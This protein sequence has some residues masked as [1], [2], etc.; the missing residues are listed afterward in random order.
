MVLIFCSAA[1]AQLVADP[2]DT[3]YTWISI[4]EERGYI[5]NLPLLRPY[6]IQLVKDILRKVKE[7]GSQADAALADL[8]LQRINVTIGDHIPDRSLLAPLSLSIENTFWTKFDSFR[9]DALANVVLQSTLGDLVSFSG[10]MSW[11]GMVQSDGFYGP[12]WL[13]ISDESE[14]GGG[15]ASIAGMQVWAKNLG[16]GG[17]AFGSADAYFQAG[18]MRSSFGPFFENGAI[19]GPQCPAAGNFSF[20]YTADWIKISSVMLIVH[21]LFYR[22]P[23]DLPGDFTLLP[24]G[25][26]SYENYLIIHSYTLTPLDWLE[27]G[28]VQTVECGGSLNPV[29]II[30][31]VNLFFAQQ[32]YGND[33]T[34]LIGLFAKIKLPFSFQFK[35]MLYVDDFNT[36]TFFG[37]NGAGLFSLDNA[38]DK[39]ALQA[40]I[41]WTP[42][43]DILERI[44]LDYLMVTPYTYTHNAGYG[45]RLSYT[46]QGVGI[47][48]IL[49]PNSDQI[50]LNAFLHPL[51]WCDIVVTG[52]FARHGNASEDEGYGGDGSYYDD[53]YNGSATFIAPARFLT[54]NVI[55]YVLQ[56]GCDINFTFGLGWSELQIGIGYM[57]EYVRNKNLLPGNEQ[58]NHFV[59]IFTKLIL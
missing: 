8:Y 50:T 16:V 41:V 2:K 22:D 56:L 28:L 27:F 4:W 11:G 51:S 44:S 36:D 6:P 12:E 7:H 49:E 24:L 15:N 30:P 58:Y 55:E 5:K 43:I 3:L 47:G 46:H 20:N 53:G 10:S 52:R 32:L 25:S 59:N 21:P 19:I 14:S 1:W 42:E 38:Q 37:K 34:S 40:G 48:T 23:N 45:N 13:S 57:F 9:D 54:Q 29:F 26:K 31:L 39:V 17:I 18:L 35:F 33:N